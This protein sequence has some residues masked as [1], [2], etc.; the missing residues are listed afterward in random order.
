MSAD[1]PPLAVFHAAESLRA[2]H[3]ALA[4]VVLALARP[5]VW[6]HLSII[7]NADVHLSIRFLNGRVQYIEPSITPEIKIT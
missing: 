7:R 1:V 4:D 5:T 3:P 2:S 6:G